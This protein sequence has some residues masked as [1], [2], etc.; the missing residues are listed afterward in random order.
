MFAGYIDP[1]FAKEVFNNKKVCLG[2][3]GAATGTA[4]VLDSGYFINGLW[5]YATG[6]PH[7]THFTANCKLQKDGA[8]LLNDNSEP[9]VRSFIFKREEVFLHHDWNTMGLKAT[10]SHSFEVKDLTVGKE[11]MFIID[12]EHCTV[13]QPL[14]QYPFLQL[15]ETTI[16]VNSLG[17]AEHFL[18][19]VHKIFASKLKARRVTTEKI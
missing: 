15:A 8:P 4:E 5:K 13:Q 3:S 7:L 11:R 18:D 9:V 19:E 14:F 10:A 6:T 2:G 1:V 17:M 16:A 12:A